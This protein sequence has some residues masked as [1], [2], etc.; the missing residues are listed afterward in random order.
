MLSYPASIPLSTRSLNHVAALIRTH[1]HRRRSR[2]RRLDPGRQALLVLAHLRN[3]DTFARL[4]AGF[5]IGLAT[6]WRYVHE[7]ITLLAATTDDLHQA[8]S[9]IRRLA[10]AILDGT[11]IPIDRVYDQKPYYSG[12][13]RRH[14]MNVQVIA[15]PAGRLVWTSA[16]LPGSAHDLTAARTHDIIAVLTSANVMTFADKA[17]QGAGGSVRTPFKRHRYRPTLSRRQK[18]VNKAHARIRAR[19]ERAVATLKTWKVLTKLRCS[20]SRTT[21]IVQAILVLHHVENPTYRG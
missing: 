20:P 12:K 5:E 6:A 13:H 16:A 7:A 14:G 9:R 19:G 11:L 1:R 21:A 2:W 17:Y 4:A 8:M 15:D 3:G 18:A 10:Y